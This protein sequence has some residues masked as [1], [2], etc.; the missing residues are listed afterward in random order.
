MIDDGSFVSGIQWLISNG[1]MNIPP[2]EQGA[3]TGGN[4]IPDWIKNNAGWWAEGQIDD[5]TLVNGMQFLIKEEIIQVS[6]TTSASNTSE[7]IPEWVK[8]TAGWWAD[9]QI[10]E[11][12]FLSA[13]QYLIRLG[14]IKID[15]DSSGKIIDDYP[16]HSEIMDAPN[17]SY[18][19]KFIL[20]DKN[21]PMISGYRGAT[22]DGV[23]VYFAPYYNN[24]GRHGLMIQY[25]TTQPFDD[26]D[27][28]DVMN[29]G[30]TCTDDDC[31]YAGFTGFQ[32][33]LHHNGF[34]YYVPY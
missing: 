15:E 9:G 30:R 8:N 21:K 27:S 10:S 1:V 33:A 20:F 28:W 7:F 5:Q 13:I 25:N 26:R 31:T 2:T 22:F 16:T 32:G 34:V 3:G 11:T 29:I 14:L 17:L 19:E 18:T 4:V 12:E 23:S 6:D 24:Y